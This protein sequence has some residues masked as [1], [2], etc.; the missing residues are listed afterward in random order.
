MAQVSVDNSS[1]C[2][3]SSRSPCKHGQQMSP[4]LTQPDAPGNTPCILD[5]LTPTTHHRTTVNRLEAPKMILRDVHGYIYDVLRELPSQ[6]VCVFIQQ[7]LLG[8]YEG[9]LSHTMSQG[10][11]ESHTHLLP[12]GAIKYVCLYHWAVCDLIQWKRKSLSKRTSLSQTKGK[13]KNKSTQTSG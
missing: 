6:T 7:C 5:P 12:L 4:F 3:K 2:V 8:F 9:S 13:N 11:V 10:G 1:A